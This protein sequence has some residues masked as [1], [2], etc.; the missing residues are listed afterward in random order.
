MEQGWFNISD[1]RASSKDE[2]KCQVL[3][4]ALNMVMTDQ[5][6]PEKVKTVMDQLEGLWRDGDTVGILVQRY[7]AATKKSSS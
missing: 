7:Q 3:N 2:N 5:S 6:D 4:A 1:H